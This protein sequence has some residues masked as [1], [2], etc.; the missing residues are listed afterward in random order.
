MKISNYESSV[1]PYSL[2]STVNLPAWR[3]KD[4]CYFN[5]FSPSVIITPERKNFLKKITA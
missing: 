1:F 4:K 3:P 2:H 5:V